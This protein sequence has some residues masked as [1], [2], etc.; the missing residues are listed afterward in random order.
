MLP[1]NVANKALSALGVTA[2]ISS[3]DDGTTTASQCKL[4]YQTALET[5]LAEF[6]WSRARRYKSVPASP[7]ASPTGSGLLFPVPPDCIRIISTGATFDELSPSDKPEIITDSLGDPYLLAT[8]TS[9]L[10]VK[11]TARVKVDKMPE[12]FGV[13]V[14]MKLASLLCGAVAGKE[15]MQQTVSTAYNQAL[16]IAV[17]A[18][19]QEAGAQFA[20]IHVT[21]FQP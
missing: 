12:E 9:P 17:G 3:L 5:V 21:R 13:A 11:Y 2:Q 7:I 8:A 10:M 20:P 15:S 19:N 6:D 4:W 18:E 1:V 14:A 16:A